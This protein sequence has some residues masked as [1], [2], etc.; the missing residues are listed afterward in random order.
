MPDLSIVGFGAYVLIAPLTA[1]ALM[2]MGMTLETLPQQWGPGGLVVDVACLA[3]V[4]GVL[5][6]HCTVRVMSVD[7]VWLRVP[8][9]EAWVEERVAR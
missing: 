5:T 7:A 3:D 1:R 8:A 6:P 2:V 4:L 9:A